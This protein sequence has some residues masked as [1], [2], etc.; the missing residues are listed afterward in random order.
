VGIADQP[1]GELPERGARALRLGY[2]LAGFI[3]LGLGIIG[4]FLPLLPT[5][6]FIILAA[7]CFA[8][9]NRRLERWLLENKQFGPMIHAWRAER[10]ISR[11]SKI[12]AGLGMVLGY[13]L[14]LIGARPDLWLTLVV[15]CFFLACAWYVF[16]RPQPSGTQHGDTHS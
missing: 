12:M 11:R 6:I 10:A 13:A 2:L 8:R 5:T 3:C 16:S 7:G 14:F 15:L 9:S 4:A 1:S